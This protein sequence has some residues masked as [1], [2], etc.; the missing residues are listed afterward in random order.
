VYSNQRGPVLFSSKSTRQIEENFR[1]VEQSTIRSD[2]VKR[3]KEL[4][5]TSGAGKN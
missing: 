4:V 2:Q 1:S 3:F 5:V